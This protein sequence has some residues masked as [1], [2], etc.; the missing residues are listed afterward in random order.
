MT[1]ALLAISFLAACLF[2]AWIRAVRKGWEIRREMK[3]QLPHTLR[4]DEHDE[5]WVDEHGEPWA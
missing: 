5:L 1:L 3:K 2:G 4:W